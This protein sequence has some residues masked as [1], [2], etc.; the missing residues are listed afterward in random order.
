[1]LLAVDVGLRTG[2]SFYDRS[3]RLLWYRSHNMGNAP[4]LRRA[5]AALLREYAPTVLALEGGGDL[6]RIWLVEA[7]TRNIPVL[8][9]GAEKWREALLPYKD[10]LSKDIA[11]KAADLHA[12]KVINASG[13]K[14]PTSLRHDAAEAV[15]IGLYAVQQLGWTESLHQTGPL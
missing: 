7:R 6:T 13:A 4:R 14:K 2:L 9:M 8:Q 3:G 1:M 11:K 10:R 5:A 15:L 12:R